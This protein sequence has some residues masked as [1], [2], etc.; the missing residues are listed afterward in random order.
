V[1]IAGNNSVQ[2]QSG[3][4]ITNVSIAA[5]NGSVAAWHINGGVPMEVMKPAEH[6]PAIPSR[7]F[8]G[9]SL[10]LWVHGVAV[11]ACIFGAFERGI[12]FQGALIAAANLGLAGVQARWLYAHR[13]TA[14]E[15]SSPEPP[16][17]DEDEAFTSGPWL[18]DLPVRELHAEGLCPRCG[19]LDV[20]HMREPYS[21]LMGDPEGA[22]VIRTCVKCRQTWGE[23]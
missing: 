13:P 7:I 22:E 21:P 11:M 6:A 8:I 5:S 20:H 9:R 17:A 15:L 18:Y 23:K 2:I 14:P 1:Q 3:G 16:A 19:W 10:L 4:S 12:T